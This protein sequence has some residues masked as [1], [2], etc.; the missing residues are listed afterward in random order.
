MRIHEHRPAVVF[1]LTLAVL[2]AGTGYPSR[3]VAAGQGPNLG[4][5]ILRPGSDWRS[6]IVPGR[7]ITIDVGVSNL[8]GDAA[9]RDTALTVHLPSGLSLKESRPAPNKTETA[10]DGVRLTWNLG[11][12]EAG[13]FPKMFDLDVQ[14]AADLKRGT[15]LA[16]EASVS[17]TDK[18]V[19]ES[20]TRTA[21]VLSVENAAAD[22]IMQSNLDGVPFTVD[23]P[24]DFTVEV[25]NFG[26]VSASACVLKMTVPAKAT[27]KSSDQGPFDKSGNVV[28]WELGDIAPAQS[29]SVKVEVE[30][31]TILRAAAYGL[32]RKQGS[33]NFKFDATTPTGIFN[34]DHG[35]LEIGRYPE[36]AGSNVTVAINVPGA[37]Y[38]GELPVGRDATFEIIYGNFGNAPA[39]K[40]TVSL[41]LP[42]GLDLVG[43][44]PA[45]AR[46]TK[47]DKSGPSVSSWDLGDLR[48]GESGII[49]SQ[50]HVTS[51][52]ADG[53]LVSAAISA[54][55]NDVP[56]R[57]KTAYSLQRAAN[58]GEK[59]ADALRRQVAAARGGHTMLWL[60]LIAVLAAVVV[61][62]FRRARSKPAS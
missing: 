6:L 41:T 35:H 32:A 43:A 24:V 58:A 29:H 60:F 31:D 33:L 23:S 11:V 26:T 9:A 38:P 55:G 53:S 2:V 44:V 59:V 47:G 49:K 16:I 18:V 50:V 21:F 14:A 22:L 17:T 46:S 57:E 37:E 15:A 3:V 51:I 28:T 62:M 4:V 20:N 34:P 45:A 1:A 48:V 25:T 30:L 27:F 8:R 39:S 13:A 5:N 40:V 42:N 10:E 54:A 61:W 7:T 12:M 56:S 52:G 36:P 19:D